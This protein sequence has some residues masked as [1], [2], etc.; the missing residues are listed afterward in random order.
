MAGL[1]GQPDLA[2]PIRTYR[3]NFSRPKTD[4]FS[5]DYTAVLDPYRVDPL[6]APTA[7]TPASVA[8]HIYT[9]SQQGDPTAFLL[10]HT[11]PGLMVDRD[12]GRVSLL[13]LVS[14]YASRMG[15]LPCRWDGETFAN[16]GNVAY[17][18]APLDQWYPAYLHLALSVLVPSAATI[19]AAI[20]GDPD[21]KLLGPYGAGDAGVE[22]IRCH[23]TVYVPVPYVGLLLGSDLT[24]IES[25]QRVREPLST[26]RRRTCVD[27]S[28]TD[29]EPPW[30][31]PEQNLSPRSKCQNH[32]RP[33]QTRSCYSTFTGC[34]LAT[35]PGWTQ[36]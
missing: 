12:P 4:P 9:A 27:P 24:P 28:S 1:I 7:T 10:W 6:N 26:H 19:N 33:Y 30:S 20:D 31:D 8:H 16:R 18:T 15:R 34:F 3:A 25:W 23:K 35:F 36:A 11:T 32:R 22:S 17:G 13:H 5:G 29:S 2:P 21:L 14:Y